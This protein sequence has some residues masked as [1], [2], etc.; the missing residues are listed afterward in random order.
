MPGSSCHD[1]TW[2]PMILGGEWVERGGGG[3][4]SGKRISRYSIDITGGQRGS[5]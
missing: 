2:L 4:G 3:G 1:V 5:K